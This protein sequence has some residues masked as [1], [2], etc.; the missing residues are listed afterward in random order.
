MSDLR[1]WGSLTEQQQR[2]ALARAREIIEALGGKQVAWAEVARCCGLKRN[3]ALRRR[4]DPTWV[5]P[6]KGRK[7]VVFSGDPKARMKI[8]NDGRAD[9]LAA[10][11]ALARLAEIPPDTRSLTGRLFGDPLPGRSAL[12][13][14]RQA[15]SSK[16][17]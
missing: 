11:D 1:D 12:D 14:K 4:L 16:R 7:K 2:R 6:D 10:V 8:Y 3:E 17:L 5:E 13:V 9:R 15:H